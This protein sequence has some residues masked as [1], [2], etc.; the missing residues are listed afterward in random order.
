MQLIAVRWR[1]RLCG[2]SFGAER[3]RSQV[4]IGSRLV[5]PMA[6]LVWVRLGRRA[7]PIE[8]GG[9]G[10]V[11]S[12]DEIRHPVRIQERADRAERLLM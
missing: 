5:L 9:G 2:G 3:T 12:W 7:A 4:P 10:G 8:G 6:G 11:W 1:S